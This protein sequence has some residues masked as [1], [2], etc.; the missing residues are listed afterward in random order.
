MSGKKSNYVERTQ[1]SG[2]KLKIFNFL[3]VFF[4]LDFLSQIFTIY[5]TAGERGGYLFNTSTAS[6]NPRH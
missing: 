6:Q 5:M 1:L 3:K 2:V 4:Y